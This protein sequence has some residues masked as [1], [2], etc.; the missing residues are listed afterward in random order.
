MGLLVWKRWALVF[1]CV[2]VEKLRNLFYFL[3]KN[4]IDLCC[5]LLLDKL[6]DCGSFSEYVEV[7]QHF[8]S[9]LYC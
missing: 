8:N 1:V 2:L 4:T 3:V 9:I 7:F 6:D 5:S